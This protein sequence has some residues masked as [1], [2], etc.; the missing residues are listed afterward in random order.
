[1]AVQ[2]LFRL[3]DGRLIF[4]G[5]V[6]GQPSLIPHSLAEVWVDGEK[7]S[8]PFRIEGEMIGANASSGVVGRRAVSTTET[9]CLTGD[10]LARGRWEL[11]SALPRPLPSRPDER[12][13]LSVHRHL[14]G[15]ESPPDDHL[16]DPMTQGPVLPEGWDGDAWVGIK[17]RGY[18]L[19]AWNAGTGRIAY[20]RGTTYKE[21][22]DALL[23]EVAEGAHRVT[24]TP[25]VR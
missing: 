12:G 15:L 24:V 14:L 19:R 13:S 20:G 25:S 7:K 17:G 16:P 2:D 23:A 8:V 21:A 22:R 1:M 6:E 9:R 4:T 18:F 10:S 11:R 5:T 3:S